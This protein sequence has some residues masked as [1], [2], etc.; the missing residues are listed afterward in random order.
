MPELDHRQ[1]MPPPTSTP[2]DGCIIYAYDRSYP[3]GTTDAPD[4]VNNRPGM[5]D[6]K[7]GEIR[8][9]RRIVNG[10][11]V[12]VIEYAESATGITPAC[13]G[14]TGDYSTNPATCGTCGLVPV[15]RSQRRST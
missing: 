12:G 7:N 6:Q 5:L 8:G 14:G 1:G 10:N 13:N 15:E 2:T 4:G 11:G 3:N 9:L